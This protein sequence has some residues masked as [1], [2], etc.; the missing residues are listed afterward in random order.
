[1][2]AGNQVVTLP[3]GFGAVNLEHQKTFAIPNPE[4]LAEEFQASMTAPRGREAYLEAGDRWLE[5]LKSTH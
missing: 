4:D 2:L 5:P 3:R 1:M